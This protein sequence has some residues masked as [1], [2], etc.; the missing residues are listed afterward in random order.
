LAST[1]NLDLYHQTLFAVWPLLKNPSFINLACDVALQW[2]HGASE[3]LAIKTIVLHDLG[4][5]ELLPKLCAFEALVKPRMIDV[6][7]GFASLAEFNHTLTETIRTAAETSFEPAGKAIIGG[8]RLQNMPAEMN[9]AT[10]A[11]HRLF[12]QAV[13]ACAQ[14]LSASAAFPFL[15]RRPQHYQLTVWGNILKGKGYEFAHYHADGWISGVYYPKLPAVL[16]QENPN[17]EAWIEFGTPREDIPFIKNGWS[18]QGFKPEEGKMIL[19][20]SFLWHRTVP[21]LGEDER[22]S[23][24]FDAAPI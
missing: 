10:A 3:A 16:K 19:F 5:S 14:D 9:A 2:K 20:P 12:Q 8:Y 18:T 15:Q 22:V 21:Y 1:N 11:L 24:A 7:E 6:P 13:E 4:D 23:I 17:H